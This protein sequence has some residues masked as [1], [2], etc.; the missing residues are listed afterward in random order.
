MPTA[1]KAGLKLDQFK[2]NHFTVD[3]DE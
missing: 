3:A 1:T 2:V